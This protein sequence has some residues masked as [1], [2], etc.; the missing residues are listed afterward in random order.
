MLELASRAGLAL[1]GWRGGR[2]DLE[3]PAARLVPEIGEMLDWLQA[4]DGANFVRMSGSG[5]T[6]FA[7]FDSET[8]RDGAAAIVPGHWWHLATHLR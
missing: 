3:A 8:D 1:D 6:C 4:Q 2:N 5:A 7:L